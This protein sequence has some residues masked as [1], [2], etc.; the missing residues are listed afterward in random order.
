MS[1]PIYKYMNDS[2][3]CADA[4]AAI[5][6]DMASTSFLL[7]D[8]KISQ[9]LKTV[10]GST[11]LYDFF[12]E[13]AKG[14]DFEKVFED[15]SVPYAENRYLLKLPKGK[16]EFASFVLA[17]LLK[18]DTR[19]ID[20]HQ[21]L[22]YFF[23]SQEGISDSYAQFTREVII[24]FKKVVLGTLKENFPEISSG[25][26]G[27][28][29]DGEELDAGQIELLFEETARL[30]LSVKGSRLKEREKEEVCSVLDGFAH[31]VSTKNKNLIKVMWISLRN[32]FKAYNM[33]SDC[34]RMEKALSSAGIN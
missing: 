11:K 6:D 16:K 1:K 31:S 20:L 17:L 23:Y 15:S 25:R 28:S 32:T 21:F 10:A 4:F 5:C 33:V 27:G 7:A 13:S 8:G 30:K 22:D 3:E 26:T 18:F 34:E 12:T 19:E 9:L 24:E 29:G 2:A 14:F